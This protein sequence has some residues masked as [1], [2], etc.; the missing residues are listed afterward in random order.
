MHY[1]ATI[2]SVTAR[3]TDDS[4]MPTADHHAVQ[5]AK[6]N[7][8]THIINLKIGQNGEFHATTL[9]REQLIIFAV[10]SLYRCESWML[11]KP[12]DDEHLKCGL[13]DRTE[14]EWVVR[15]S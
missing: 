7:W 6:K 10:S 13:G 15:S 4:I 12:D 8:V 2:N 9:L 14:N 5:L 1:L 11:Q 3:W